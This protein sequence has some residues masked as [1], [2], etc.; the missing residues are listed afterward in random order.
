MGAFWKIWRLQ[1]CASKLLENWKVYV[2]NVWKCWNEI[3]IWNLEIWRIGNLEIWKFEDFQFFW[4][5]GDWLTVSCWLGLLIASICFMTWLPKFMIDQISCTERR[6]L[7]LT[8]ASYWNFRDLNWIEMSI[9]FSIMNWALYLCVYNWYW[10]INQS[11]NILQMWM[12]ITELF[13]LCYFTVA[14]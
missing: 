12:N 14:I 13:K 4:K 10:S 2:P 6:V 9:A 7:N 1:V 3:E 11:I 5:K 8:P